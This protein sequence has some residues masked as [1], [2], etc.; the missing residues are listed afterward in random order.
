[1]NPIKWKESL[2]NTL[3]T[4]VAISLTVNV[5]TSGRLNLLSIAPVVAS[6]LSLIVFLLL[7]IKKECVERDIDRQLAE[8]K[9]CKEASEILKPRTDVQIIDDA[10]DEK[11]IYANALFWSGAIFWLL[12]VSFVYYSNTLSSQDE[13]IIYKSLSDQNAKIIQRVSQGASAVQQ[14]EVLTLVR[15]QNDLIKDI[16]AKNINDKFEQILRQLQEQNNLI[17]LLVEAQSKPKE[18]GA[19]QKSP[20]ATNQHNSAVN[21]Q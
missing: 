10:Y 6:T 12:A 7:A 2:I 16:A 19:P 13:S 9:Q 15:K 17:R 14:D 1:M 11:K 8:K 21:H 5:V 3:F 20:D 18:G 4:T